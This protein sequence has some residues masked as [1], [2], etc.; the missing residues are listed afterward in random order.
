[1]PTKEQLRDH[2]R[3]NLRPAIEKVNAA[4]QGREIKD[5]E[6][7]LER[8]GRDNHLPHWYKQLKKKHKLPNIDGKTV[9]SVI[10]MI[11]V[12]VL[13]THI[14]KGMGIP[15]LKINPARGVDLPNL[16]LGIKSPSKNFCTSEPFF[17]A[18]ERLLGN[19]YDILVLLTDYQEAKSKRRPELQ[20]TDW[21]YLQNTEVADRNLC[22]IALKHRNFLIKKNEAWAKKV[23]RF[24]AYAN[25]S[26][27]SAR[28]LLKLID[29]LQDESK[30]KGLVESSSEDFKTQNLL[31]LKK[32][33][34]LIP[35]E[36]LK[37]MVDI[38]NVKPLHLGVID[39]ADNW[40]AE[41]QKEVAR[42]P[43]DNEWN[44][45]IV[46]PLNGKIGMSFALQWRYNFGRLFGVE[47]DKVEDTV[48][49]VGEE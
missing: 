31:K 25:Q 40:I 15:P 43:N 24:L 37:T 6:K 32:D 30:I 10:E 18:Y 39:A 12:A 19:E 9:G 20:I 46:S 14:F 8:L 1:M 33:S 35:D 3:K 22:R 42:L 41:T 28:W 5:L 13:E 16:D 2:L 36:E 48:L 34:E 49:P 29:N 38:L 17:S 21:K 4:L 23:F 7:V 27:W 11:F 26:E 47:L 44:R 45:L